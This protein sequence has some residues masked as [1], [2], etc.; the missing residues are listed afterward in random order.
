MFHTSDLWVRYDFET[1]LVRSTAASA[2][3]SVLLALVAIS[4]FLGNA[5]LAVLVMVANCCCIL[6]LGAWLF[7]VLGWEFGAIEALALIIV[8][9]LSVDYTLHIA[10]CY[11]KS[12]CATAR[13]KVQDALRRTGSALVGSA[14]TS[15]LACPPIMFCTIEVFV[16][17]G[18]VIISSMVLSLLFG[19]IFFSAML[20]VVSPNGSWWTS[21]YRRL[22]VSSLGKAMG[23]APEQA[24]SS[25]FM[26]ARG[27]SFQE[28]SHFK[29]VTPTV[30][31]QQSTE[32][33]RI[34]RVAWV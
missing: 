21:L 31:R 23:M 20:V 30:S 16:R 9:G 18:A 24:L 2:L 28:A 3:A 5:A 1:R 4:F 13:L 26:V 32:P 11:Q 34:G 29:D 27:N 17:F 6:C 22:S 33:Q 7:V 19:L 15:V 12:S 25:G 8:V 14:S 10:Q